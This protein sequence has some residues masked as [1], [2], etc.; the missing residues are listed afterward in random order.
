MASK[1]MFPKLNKHMDPMWASQTEVTLERWPTVEDTQ[2]RR[3][4]LLTGVGLL[5]VAMS[6]SVLGQ[7][8]IECLPRGDKSE[9]LGSSEDTDASG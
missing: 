7:A 6:L 8:S 9:Y 2:G 3:H 4:W 1:Q 5:R